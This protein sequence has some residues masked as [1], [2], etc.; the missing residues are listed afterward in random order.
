VHNIVRPA[1]LLCGAIFGKSFVGLDFC[2]EE[3]QIPRSARDDNARR[4]DE[5]DT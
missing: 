1:P 4:R 5:K 3:M 2:F